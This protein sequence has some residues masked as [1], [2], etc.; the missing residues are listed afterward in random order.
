LAK[1]HEKII[2]YANCNG[3]GFVI[4]GFINTDIDNGGLKPTMD[5]LAFKD[6]DL[7]DLH[8]I[9]EDYT[10]MCNYIKKNNLLSIHFKKTNSDYQYRLLKSDIP[11][12]RIIF[13]NLDGYILTRGII[14]NISDI[15]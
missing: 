11:H 9:S 12:E 5:V 14:F 3:G 4:N 2:V 10:E 8:E 6:G 15:A 7:F 13:F 1:K